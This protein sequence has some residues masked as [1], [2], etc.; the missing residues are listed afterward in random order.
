MELLGSSVQVI[1]AA[2]GIFSSYNLIIASCVVLIL[3][4]F[5][6]EL[7]K[8]TNVPSVLM[9]IVLGILLKLGLDN[10]SEEEFNFLPYLEVLGIVGLI[11]IVLEAALELEL[12]RE[13]M[14]P[15][16]KA[17]TIALV[18]LLLSAWAAAFLL[19]YFIPVPLRLL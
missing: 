12:V 6:G 4:F 18:G 1:A 14:I 2:G 19:N 13:K 10:M 5:F 9:L 16:A 3:S 11:M 17:F 15:I 7:S 8:R